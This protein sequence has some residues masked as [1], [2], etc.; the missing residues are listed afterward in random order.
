VETT[1][2]VSIIAGSISAGAVLCRWVWLEH[3]FAK[4]M[5]DAR[6]MAQCL[7]SL[8]AENI[9]L[10][11]QLSV[12]NEILKSVQKDIGAVEQIMQAKADAERLDNSGYHGLDE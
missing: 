8:H 4:V 10:K 11:A 6:K 2:L 1:Q 7:H 5:V 12:N 3:Q 9:G